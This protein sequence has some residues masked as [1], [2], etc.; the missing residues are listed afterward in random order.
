VHDPVRELVGV[1]AADQ[2]HRNP[3]KNGAKFKI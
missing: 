3:R 1:G 2:H